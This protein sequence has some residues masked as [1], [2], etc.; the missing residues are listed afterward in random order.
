MSVT[1]F[2]P[3]FTLRQPLLAALL[4]AGL[5]TTQQAG[6]VGNAMDVQVIDRSSGQALPMYS[7]QGE[8]WVAG[9]P[10]ARYAIG[11]RNLQ[12]H[13]RPLRERRAGGQPR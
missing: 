12:R 5:A 4:L 2:R 6:A 11:V 1:H 8:Y 10:G 7:H 3:L 9:Q 13:R